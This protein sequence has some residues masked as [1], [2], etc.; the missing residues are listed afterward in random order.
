MSVVYGSV[1]MCHDW[2]V[3]HVHVL[4]RWLCISGVRL[5]IRLNVIDIF[6]SVYLFFF[7]QPAGA[8]IDMWE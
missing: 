6:Y 5:R 1:E 2:W 3:Q 8:R 4:N 7:F